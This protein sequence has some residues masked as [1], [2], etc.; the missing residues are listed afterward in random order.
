MS[1]DPSE[2]SLPDRMPVFPLPNMVLFPGAFVPLHI[3]EPRY[4]RMACDA[5]SAG[6][7]LALALLKP[8]F[9]PL[10]YTRRAPI[11]AV[12][13]V[14]RIVAHERLA[15]GKFNLLVNGVAR[16]RLIEHE[17]DRPYRVAR[18]EPLTD[19]PPLDD[20]VA[21]RL[22]RDLKRTL[23]G[24]A[25]P[26]ELREYWC[27]LLRSERELPEIVDLCAHALP[28]DGELRQLLLADVN[29]ATRAALFMDYVRTFSDVYR[30]HRRI[31]PEPSATVN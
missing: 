14:G 22:R 4:R 19:E 28:I 2:V 3:F 24:A 12:A 18:V 27:E 9:E 23:D 6:G 17:C 30:R 15:E 16:G 11:H 8:G 25:A 1:V 5:L 31:D 29:A 20:L 13:G 10:Y 7:C 26:L 21:R